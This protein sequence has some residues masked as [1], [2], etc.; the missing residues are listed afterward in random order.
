MPLEGWLDLVYHRSILG[1]VWDEDHP[2][3]RFSV[4]INLNDECIGVT[5]ADLM[6]ADLAAAGKGDG[7]Y[8]F[9]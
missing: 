4:Q 2:Q 7:R 6:R 5:T 9:E 8:A 1:W 3:Y